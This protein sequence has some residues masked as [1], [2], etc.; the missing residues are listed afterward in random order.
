MIHDGYGAR[1]S[2]LEKQI[3]DLNRGK[4]ESALKISNIEKKFL[5]KIECLQAKVSVLENG[6]KKNVNTNSESN[7]QTKNDKTQNYILGEES[8]KELNCKLCD[9]VLKSE[10][11]LLNCGKKVSYEERNYNL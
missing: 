2:D 7:V 5:Y 6:F 4:D 11:N 9:T 1:I 8:R 10:S 3:D